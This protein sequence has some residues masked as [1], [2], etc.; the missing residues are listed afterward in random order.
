MMNSGELNFFLKNG[1]ERKIVLCGFLFI[2]CGVR[3][4]MG[5]LVLDWI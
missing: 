5:I 4:I 2:F 1:G 3:G